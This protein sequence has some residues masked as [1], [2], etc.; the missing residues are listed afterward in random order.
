[1]LLKRA[2]AVSGAST[3]GWRGRPVGML[4]ARGVVASGRCSAALADFNRVSRSAIIALMDSAPGVCIGCWGCCVAA[5]AGWHLGRA[6]CRRRDV[7]Q[8]GSGW[9]KSLGSLI[10]AD[11]VRSRVDLRYVGLRRPGG[12]CGRRHALAWLAAATGSGLLGLIR[13]S[14]V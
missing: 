14:S 1:M 6:G 10:V 13:L 12:G 3:A 9:P 8:A 4:G 7:V 11:A 5:A 2:P